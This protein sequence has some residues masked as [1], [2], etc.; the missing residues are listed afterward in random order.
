MRLEKGSKRWVFVKVDCF[1][2]F[3]EG[4]FGLPGEIA[5]IF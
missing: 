4:P 5:A 1:F 3:R 2:A